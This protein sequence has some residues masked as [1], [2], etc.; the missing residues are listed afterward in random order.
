MR[1]FDKRIKAHNSLMSKGIGAFLVVWIL[2]AA[3][4]LAGTIALVYIVLH[5]VAKFW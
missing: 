2:A 3:A 4:G 1:D 5:F